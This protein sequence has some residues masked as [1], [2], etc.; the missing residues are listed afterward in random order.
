MKIETWKIEKITPYARNPRKNKDAIPKV[1]ASLKEFGW[2][3]PIV[4]DKDGVVIVGHTR[5]AA[6]IELGMTE[7]PVHV[8]ENLTLEQIKAYRILD[9]KTSEYAEWDNDLLKLEL[10]DISEFN[11]DEFENLEFEG[12]GDDKEVIEDDFEAPPEDQIQ[13]DI[14]LSLIHI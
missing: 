2:Q 13:T 3:Q 12:I 6:A 11:F 10:A 5:L 8:A 7:V 1:K 9:N 14:K 4:V